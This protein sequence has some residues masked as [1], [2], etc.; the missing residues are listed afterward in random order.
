MITVRACGLV[1]GFP[2]VGARHEINPSKVCARTAFC[3]LVRLLNAFNDV[4]RAGLSTTGVSGSVK[5]DAGIK[6]RKINR[7]T[8]DYQSVLHQPPYSH[9]SPSSS[10]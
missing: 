8:Q 5:R 3:S 9:H 4:E 6:N 7:T 1:C 2:G 10:L